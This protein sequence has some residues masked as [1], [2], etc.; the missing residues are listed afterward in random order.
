MYLVTIQVPIY[1][2]GGERLVATDWRRSLMLLRDSFDG[3]FGR[4]QVVAPSLDARTAASDQAL[5]P[6]RES[7]DIELYPSFPAD[8]SLRDFWK[9][10]VRVWYRD[11]AALLPGA[12]IVHAGFCDVYRPLDYIGFLSA[13][14][15]DKPTVFV[16]DTD[17]VQ[18]EIELSRGAPLPRRILGRT[19][20][21]IYERCV[22]FGV[23]HASL[24]LLKGRAL[25]VRYGHF[26]KNAHNFHD[27]SYFADEV[28]AQPV[29]EQR[30]QSLRE[31]R[32][33][34]FVYVG[35][36]EARKGVDHSIDA[37][38]RARGAGARVTF[39][40]IGDGPERN[41]LERMVA[42]LDLR[43]SVRFLGRRVYGRELLA[44]L[45]GYD[46]LLF[47]PLAEDTPRMIFDGYASGLP[48]VG[49]GIEYVRERE[50]EDGAARSV[51]ARDTAAAGQ[52]LIAL[53]RE[54]DQL[55]KLALRAREAALYHSA[56][57]WYT[58]RAEWTY[59]AAA[60]YRHTR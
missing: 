15:A 24:S 27:T 17:Q 21:E 37:V 30:V 12:D 10:D 11:I 20:A 47:T 13:L 19:Y 58:R 22:R 2:H 35:R 45:A 40:I 26:A 43:E 16:Q 34:R 5:E 60:K 56:D 57:A 9:R 46:A 6:M 54:R 48:L 28:V 23:Q 50:A 25:H 36:L 44:D 7:D 32:P 41:A 49:Y 39:D 31:P 59:E 33:L 18:Q 8:S 53:D 52:L 55:A 1:V 4:I 3:R 42:N 38:A 14:Q 29:L 51:P